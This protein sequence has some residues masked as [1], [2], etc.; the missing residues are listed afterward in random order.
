MAADA[1]ALD[2]DGLLWQAS[3]EGRLMSVLATLPRARWTERSPSG[4]S[5]LH[6]ASVGDNPI[7]AAAL[8]AHGLDANLL[9]QQGYMPVHWASAGAP[10]VLR[11]LCAGGADLCAPN[12]AGLRPLECALVYGCVPCVKVLVANGVRLS[13][14]RPHEFAKP[15]LEAFERGV[16]RCRA[17]AVVLMGLQR[18]RRCA[19]MRAL[20]RW[21]VR[22]VALSVW[23]TRTEA[24]WMAAPKSA[25]CALQ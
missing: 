10:R 1:S 16:L 4:K 17:A 9:D 5:L 22:E 12:A 25:G 15:E 6:L 8:L 13:S 20:D 7:A 24:V 3:R 21:A 14:L 19:S 2:W 11:M 23:S 18:L